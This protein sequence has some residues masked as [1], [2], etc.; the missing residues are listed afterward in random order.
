MDPLNDILAVVK[1]QATLL[2]W[3]HCTYLN[4]SVIARDWPLTAYN[5]LKVSGRRAVL[6]KG[7]VIPSSHI[8]SSCTI[9]HCYFEKVLNERAIESRQPVGM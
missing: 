7:V 6:D 2:P 4:N 8:R 5:R 3:L 1:P 9:I